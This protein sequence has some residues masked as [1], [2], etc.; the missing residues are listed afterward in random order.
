[1]RH[2]TKMYGE[3]VFYEDAINFCIEDTYPKHWRRHDVH[4]VDYPED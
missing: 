1:M 2:I 3:G 4:P